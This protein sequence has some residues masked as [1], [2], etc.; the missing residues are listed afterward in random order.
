MK[1]AGRKLSHLTTV[2]VLLGLAAAV[3]GV[4]DWKTD[5]RRSEKLDL[6]RSQAVELDQRS[7]LDALEGKIVYAVGT[8]TGSNPTRDTDFNLELPVLRLERESE[9]LQWQEQGGKHRNYE[10]VWSSDEVDSRS[11]RYET[12]HV[13]RGVIEYPNF[14]TGPMDINLVSGNRTLARLDRSYL[15]FMGG[16]RKIPVKQSMYDA[17]PATV[18]ARFALVDGSLVEARD[19]GR[20]DDPRI[21]D[22]RTRFLGIS[23]MEVSVVGVLKSGVIVPSDETLGPVAILQPGSVSMGRVFETVASDIRTSAIILAVV[24]GFMMLVAIFVF[25]KDFDGAPRIREIIRFGR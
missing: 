19:G 7:D 16:A 1:F 17:M 22:N 5:S 20:T 2:A 15:Q 24:A 4:I 25:L 12:D 21:G 10:A 23:P 9:I 3:V 14:T 13:N 18:K 8:A 6:I 11:F